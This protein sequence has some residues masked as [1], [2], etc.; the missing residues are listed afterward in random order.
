[1]LQAPLG[2]RRDACQAAALTTL[3]V[4]ATRAS[5]RRGLLADGA[6]WACLRCLDG[7]LAAARDG[8]SPHTSPCWGNGRRSKFA[9]GR[10]ACPGTPTG[11]LLKRSNQLYSTI[12]DLATGVRY[13]ERVARAPYVGGPHRVALRLLIALAADED[14]L[15]R[16]VA[17]AAVYGASCRLTSSWDPVVAHLATVL[18][19]MLA[20]ERRPGEAPQ[21]PTTPLFTPRS[22]TPRSQVTEEKENHG[23]GVSSAGASSRGGLPAGLFTPFN[24][25]PIPT[26]P[27]PPQ[28]NELPGSS[29]VAKPPPRDGNSSSTPAT[30]VT[31]SLRRRVVFDDVAD[32]VAGLPGACVAKD[33]GAQSARV[34]A[35]S[36][37][38]ARRAETAVAED[39]VVPGSPSTPG[40][41]RALQAQL[42][43][44]N[45][46]LSLWPARAAAGEA[47]VAAT[48]AGTS[49]RPTGAFI[50]ETLARE[51]DRARRRARYRV[52]L[53]AWTAWRAAVD[54]A[55][56]GDAPAA[57]KAMPGRTRSATHAGATRAGGYSLGAAVAVEARQ[58]S[59]TVSVDVQTGG[60][61][62]T[63]GD[64]AAS[65][66]VATTPSVAGWGGSLD[67]GDPPT[68]HEQE[69]R[70]APEERRGSHVP[71]K[72]LAEVLHVGNELRA[73]VEAL[74]SALAEEREAHRATESALQEAQMEAE[75][76]AEEASKRGHE[77][78]VQRAVAI[79][80]VDGGPDA[81]ADV[82]EQ[83]AERALAAALAQEA[84][85]S[86]LRAK[87]AE[88]EQMEASLADVTAQLES[89]RASAPSADASVADRTSLED[90]TLEA[91][92]PVSESKVAPERSAGPLEAAPIGGR[93]ATPEV[94]SESRR[95]V[96]VAY[97]EAES[98]GRKG[99]LDKTPAGAADGE[100]PAA[101]RAMN[102]AVAQ[103]REELPAKLMAAL[104]D[105]GQHAPEALR[106]IVEEALQKLSAQNSPAAS[107]KPEAIQLVV[108][109]NDGPSASGSDANQFASAAN[110]ARAQ[111]TADTS[112]RLPASS[113][114]TSGGE[115]SLLSLIVEGEAQL[116]EDVGGG[117]GEATAGADEQPSVSLSFSSAAGRSAAAPSN[118]QPAGCDVQKV[119]QP[120]AL[121]TEDDG[122]IV[123][124][125]IAN[126]G[127]LQAAIN[128]AASGTDP[129]FVDAPSS[130]SPK[131]G[132]GGVS[133]G[134]GEGGGGAELALV[135]GTGGV[136]ARQDAAAGSPVID[137]TV[138][139]PDGAASSID[140]GDARYLVLAEAKVDL[141]HEAR[142]ALADARGSIDSTLARLRASLSQAALLQT[143]GDTLDE[144]TARELASVSGLAL[145]EEQIAEALVECTALDTSGRVDAAKLAP[146]LAA[147]A[148]ANLD[149]TSEVHAWVDTM[150]AS[151]RRELS[152]AA[153]AQA[154]TSSAASGTLS[155][156]A[157]RELTVAA[158]LPL[159]DEEITA[160]LVECAVIDA[161]GRVAPDKL[162]AALAAKAKAN[163]DSGAAVAASAAVPAQQSL[164]EVAR[165]SVDLAAARLGAELSQAVAS[166]ASGRGAGE[167]LS[168]RA[169]HEM[170]T[171]SGL[172]LSEAQ[173]AD[174]LL[175]SAA[176]HAPGR[177]EPERLADA[178]AARAR[179]GGDGAPSAAVPTSEVPTPASA[180]APDG[181]SESIDSAVQ[182]LGVELSQA[183]QAKARE[184]DSDVSDV[185]LLDARAARDLVA[186]SGLPLCPDQVAAALAECAAEDAPGYVEH[187]QLAQMLVDKVKGSTQAG[188]GDPSAGTTVVAPGRGVAAQAATA[189]VTARHSTERSNLAV[190]EG[191]MDILER[192][193]AALGGETSRRIASELIA[194][195]G[196]ADTPSEVQAVVQAVAARMSRPEETGAEATIAGAPSAGTSSGTALATS[197]AT[198]TLDTLPLVAIDT[199]VSTELDSALRDVDAIE[200]RLGRILEGGAAGAASAAFSAEVAS[201]EADAATLTTR[202]VGVALAEGS[203]APSLLTTALPAGAGAIAAGATVGSQVAAL[204]RGS[205]SGVSSV[206]VRASDPGEMARDLLGLAA[207]QLTLTHALEEGVASVASARESIEGELDRARDSFLGALTAHQTRVPDADGA[208]ERAVASVYHLYALL[209]GAMARVGKTGELLAKP[210][211]SGL[212]AAIRATRD[213]LADGWDALAAFER[214][215]EGEAALGGADGMLFTAPQHH[216][217][218]DV[219]PLLVD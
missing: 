170:V 96:D 135:S 202:A 25:P 167:T 134:D 215:V 205:S 66:A 169:A 158:G 163:V 148:I 190:I 203:T 94:T 213:T 99:Q 209:R 74:E 91:E 63:P 106:A 28:W 76:E 27:P 130:F 6:V 172:A 100:V 39:L 160:A 64:L 56:S 119:P 71:A 109:A 200:R 192:I 171:D 115:G 52:A 118:A 4:A 101:A 201:A 206:S 104:G 32:D 46:A 133:S 30:D 18:A 131:G 50:P 89:K 168:A 49:D 161:P 204:V 154:T 196:G 33:D 174:A 37:V 44:L 162:A 87:R 10:L 69:S 20:G 184:P 9:A 194:R 65:L 180:M 132:A 195:V 159:L 43:E 3:L 193:S 146:A 21:T 155:V 151:L 157:A 97:N 85:D 86:T 67:S 175:K 79:E 72:M 149:S 147:K 17:R 156:L 125:A 198:P 179:G 164:L 187:V 70:R 54:C 126:V 29:K 19:E 1:M 93:S 121:L 75:R 166:Q 58:R 150:A 137:T 81:D 68:T 117:P 143:K 22:A 219:T 47:A 82:V 55:R 110:A 35:A 13:S 185:G 136:T 182:R 8:A 127:R 7:R 14:V 45:E 178:L 211:N 31:Q 140:A 57:L 216:L 111:G 217:A 152:Q 191:T 2:P 15:L 208:R 183:A 173:I 83:Q 36:G 60:T 78:Q 210:D 40:R 112:L 214:A 51:V 80:M 108:G 188:L 153:A 34:T 113:T 41:E 199:A 181:A 116:Q 124:A 103:M 98:T 145:S 186:A 177:V 92:A 207:Q 11:T 48:P 218:V 12:T 73:H 189:E 23:I 26:P 90:V 212:G 128:A 142:A 138:F 105:G 5:G 144:S 123:A 88:L 59:A 122:D 141:K 24:A 197:A 107:A 176:A 139:D 120:A 114:G 165:D 95:A 102:A 53:H 38:P 84:L 16:G 61:G 42:D 129:E 62:N 77:E